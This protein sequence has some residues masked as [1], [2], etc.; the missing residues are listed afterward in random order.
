[1]ET[2]SEIPLATGPIKTDE[3]KAE[4]EARGTRILAG[5]FSL[6]DLQAQFQEMANIPLAML[7]NVLGSMPGLGK[8][9][10][11]LEGDAGSKG[12]GNPMDPI[13]MVKR[14]LTIMDSMTNAE[15]DDPDACFSSKECSSRINRLAKGS[16]RPEQEVKALLQQ[17]KVMKKN[18][19][20]KQFSTALRAAGGRGGAVG[21]KRKGDGQRQSSAELGAVLNMLPQHLRQQ[22]N[23]GS[24]GAVKSLLDSFGGM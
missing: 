21:N 3:E 24:P 6:R 7:K 2:L 11:T 17:Y 16:G 10:K 22:M 1:M 9:F 15:L 8:L 4:D 23:L 14:F 20:S 5:S 13:I 12:K 18:M 19:G